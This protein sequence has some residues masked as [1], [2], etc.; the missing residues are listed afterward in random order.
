MRRI[1]RY[2]RRFGADQYH[3]DL[4]KRSLRLESLEQRQ[5]LSISPAGGI[6]CMNYSLQS[7]LS[8]NALNGAYQDE[9][10]LLTVVMDIA[11]EHGELYL[12]AS[13]DFTYRPQNGY[14]GVD[15]FT[16]IV[17]TADQ[18]ESQTATVVLQVLPDIGVESSDSTTVSDDAM[19]NLNIFV[20]NINQDESVDGGDILALCTPSVE[21]TQMFSPYQAA[22]W[23]THPGYAEM[24]TSWSIPIQA[25][26]EIADNQSDGAGLVDVT[27]NLVSQRNDSGEWVYTERISC[28]WSFQ[29]TEHA[30]SGEYVV[31]AEAFS[32]ETMESFYV[33][34]LLTSTETSLTP[35]NNAEDVLTVINE[36]KYTIVTYCRSKDSEDATG[37][38]I[39]TSSRRVRN[40]IG[41]NT[42]PNDAMPTPEDALTISTL[43]TVTRLNY[44]KDTALNEKIQTQLDDE[45]TM[46]NE[47]ICTGIQQTSGSDLTRSTMT[48]LDA[49]RPLT[50]QDYVTLETLQ[51]SCVADA[52]S[53]SSEQVPTTQTVATHRFNIDSVFQNGQWDSVETDVYTN[54]S[55]LE[56]TYTTSEGSNETITQSDTQSETHIRSLVAGVLTAGSIQFSGNS[57]QIRESS[58]SGV[59]TTNEQSTVN[60]VLKTRVGTGNWK[61][62]TY[63][64]YQD[65]YDYIQI[66]VNN[67]WT[68]SEGTASTHVVEKSKFQ[69]TASGS[70]TNTTLNGPGNEDDVVISGHWDKS[71]DESNSSDRTVTSIVNSCVWIDSGVETFAESGNAYTNETVDEATYTRT[72]SGGSVTGF[73]GSYEGKSHQ[74]YFNGERTL[75]ANAGVQSWNLTNG[76]GWDAKSE[77]S[78]NSYDGDGSYTITGGSG[79]GSSQESW[80]IGGEVT[81]CGRIGNGEGVYTEWSPSNGAWQAIN[82]QSVFY[83]TEQID[84]QDISDGMYTDGTM[85]GTI[86]VRDTDYIYRWDAYI[87]NDENQNI[88]T[89]KAIE[90]ANFQLTN[91]SCATGCFSSSYTGCSGYMT[92]QISSTRDD[93]DTSQFYQQTYIEF[94]LVEEASGASCCCGGGSSPP[95]YSWQ[96]DSGTLVEHF[97]R[98]VRTRQY[99]TEPQPLSSGCGNPDITSYTKAYDETDSW[100]YKTDERWEI[101]PTGSSLQQNS[102]ANRTD[103]WSITNGVRT[104]EYG[105]QRSSTDISSGTGC[106]TYDYQTVRGTF[107]T[108]CTNSFDRTVSTTMTYTPESGKWL[109]TYGGIGHESF[110]REYTFSGEFDPNAGCYPSSYSGCITCE[111]TES[112]HTDRVLTY[113][114]PSEEQNASTRTILNGPTSNPNSGCYGGFSAPGTWN[115]Y[116]WT[117][118]GTGKGEI[119]QSSW[120]VHNNPKNW[121]GTQFGTSMTGSE[122]NKSENYWIYTILFTEEKSVSGNWKYTDTDC[123]GS[124]Y[125]WSEKC[126]ESTD[127]VYSH[128]VKQGLATLNGNKDYTESLTESNWY[129]IGCTVNASGQIVFNLSGYGSQTQT[130]DYSYSGCTGETTFTNGTVSLNESG[131]VHSSQERLVDWTYDASGFDADVT[132]TKETNGNHSFTYDYNYSSSCNGYANTFNQDWSEN[133][134]W[135][136]ERTFLHT[137]SNATWN[138]LWADRFTSY[139]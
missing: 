122:S 76:T 99:T 93:S 12:D 50:L 85:C 130:I 9:G 84:Y 49:E 67:T 114:K 81:E 44:L 28:V 70:Y 109:T 121:T 135:S 101:V 31:C 108:S 56:N 102:S 55:V 66:F 2:I 117:I 126:I 48:I 52:G 90:T 113:A 1:S 95:T 51:S 33:S 39:E 94:S 36:Q 68:L 73:I 106:C 98:E 131:V 134:S 82:V 61:E 69:D 41:T 77:S 40:S 80:N 6:F 65:S 96:Y 37:R 88:L 8:G 42:D 136:N 125:F 89:G 132:T 100:A 14:I 47:W 74:Y 71:L 13:G 38:R 86:G 24:T 63:Y 7:E 124:G 128:S 57:T 10:K 133:S 75:V 118:T 92:G 22:E 62:Q 107:D 59:Y 58:H 83:N 115:S 105:S 26:S 72:I 20:D 32:T 138:V 111:D 5:M 43:F 17:S 60:G 87:S 16:C 21:P 97:S 103:L 3:K 91:A 129:D 79:T 104:E 54:E 35:G 64:S 53:E 78:G 110:G 45:H 123:G 19:E 120:T 46:S 29:T 127:N 30:W 11:P 116:G 119:S 27:R 112:Y 18:S 139:E 23:I 34:T 25:F 15:E 137:F 4:R